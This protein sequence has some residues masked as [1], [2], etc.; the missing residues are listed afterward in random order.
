M[1]PYPGDANMDPAVRTLLD[2][3]DDLFGYEVPR[4]DWSAFPHRELSA[5]VQTIQRALEDEL[6]VAFQRD[7]DVQDASFHDELH[8]LDPRSFQESGVIAIIPEVALRFSNYGRLY[9]I[10]SLVPDAL[11]R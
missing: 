11:P 7:G 1:A 10:Y 3:H 2:E 6:G 5:S 8:V 4:N 9:T